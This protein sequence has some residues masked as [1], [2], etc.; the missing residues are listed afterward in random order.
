M[1]AAEHVKLPGGLPPRV[2]VTQSIHKTLTAFRQASVIL[3]RDEWPSN[4]ANTG[5]DQPRFKQSYLANTT[6]SPSA[7][8]VASFDIAR[9]QMSIDGAEMIRDSALGAKEFASSLQRNSWAK[10]GSILRQGPVSQKRVQSQFPKDPT[11]LTLFH[12]LNKTS[13]E[14]KK[15][16]WENAQVQINKFGYDSVMFMFMPGYERSKTPN[17][18][19]RLAKLADTNLADV[20]LK[21]SKAHSPRLDLERCVDQ[22]G[23]VHSYPIGVAKSGRMGMGHVLFGPGSDGAIQMGAADIVQEAEYI[24]CSFVT[25][26][27]PGFP[28]LVPGQIVDG[29]SLVKILHSDDEIH[30]IDNEKRIL[31]KLYAQ[32]PGA[33]E[34]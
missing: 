18:L 16:L 32:P 24:C 34:G 33:S 29:A 13:G 12:K 4:V 30:G 21:K 10:V 1:Y 22:R 15:L 31:V 19:R 6:T 11:K 7:P 5:L 14:A 25:P 27:P 26:Y 9:R 20:T 8:I 23:E 3:E 17:V 2:Y 28:I